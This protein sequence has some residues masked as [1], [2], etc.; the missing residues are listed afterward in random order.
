LFLGVEEAYVR[1][2][3]DLMRC[4]INHITKLEFLPCFLAALRNQLLKAILREV[5]EALIW[6][7]LTQRR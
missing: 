3:E 2:A 7:D 5:F 6:C 4:R 1:Q